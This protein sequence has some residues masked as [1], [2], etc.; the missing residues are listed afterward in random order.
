MN[1]G[2]KGAC[3][4]TAP[5]GGGLYVIGKTNTPSLPSIFKS[6]SSINYPK[7]NRLLILLH[8]YINITNN[9]VGILLWQKVNGLA[10][11]HLELKIQK[12]YLWI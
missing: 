3:T 4:A 2:R 11:S 9:Y 7:I 12:N 8:Q 10:K 1:S 6:Y 5:D